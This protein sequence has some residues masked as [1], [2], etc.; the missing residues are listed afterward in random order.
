MPF[1]LTLACPCSCS[2]RFG[3]WSG[4]RRLIAACTDGKVLLLD[5]PGREEPLTAEDMLLNGSTLVSI[6]GTPLVT[7]L[8]LPGS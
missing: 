2:V 5:A 1:L 8:W 7:V 4:A 3:M 6:P